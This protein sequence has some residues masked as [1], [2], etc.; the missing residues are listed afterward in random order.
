MT[1]P[2]TVIWGI[3]A[4]VFLLLLLLVLFYYKLRSS[5]SPELER[6]HTLG[7]KYASVRKK[8]NRR[9]AGRTTAAVSLSKALKLRGLGDQIEAEFRTLRARSRNPA[10]VRDVFEDA[11]NDSMSEDYRYIGD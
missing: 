4:G 1:L 6:A 7:R 2:G 10:R 3:I 11:Y 9:N 5:G 8:E